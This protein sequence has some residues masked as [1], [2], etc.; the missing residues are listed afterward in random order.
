MGAN[1]DA[2]KRYLDVND[3]NRDGTS[4]DR[5]NLYGGAGSLSELAE[6]LRNAAGDPGMEGAAGQA[7]RELATEIA[8]GAAELAGELDDVVTILSDAREAVREGSVSYTMLPS[9]E[10]DAFQEEQASLVG[11]PARGNVEFEDAADMR[12]H[13]REQ[14][15]REREAEAGREMNRLDAMLRDA[16]ARMSGNTA[17]PTAPGPGGTNGAGGTGAAATGHRELSLIHI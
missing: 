7:A 6:A 10:L 17:G 2:L 5:S 3:T 13:F 9:E 12:A 4:T 14:N 1:A 11:H 8:S 15:A 16:T